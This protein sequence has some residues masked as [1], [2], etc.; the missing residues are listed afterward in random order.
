MERFPVRRSAEQK[1]DF[2]Q[3]VVERMQAQGWEARVET[4][5][6][7]KH[8]NIVIGDP[9]H[10]AAVF[11]AHYDTPADMI[12]PNLMI[13]RNL[14]VYLLYQLLFIGVLLLIGVLAGAALGSLTG[15]PQ[16][17]SVTM[18]VVYFCLLV[19]LNFGRANKNNA[20]DNTSGVAAVLQLAMTI[21]AEQREKVAFILFDNEEKGL[22]GSKMYAK[23]H[24]SLQY[25]RLV[26]NL[27]C[28]GNGD[29]MLVIS[30]DM[31]RRCTGY[32]KLESILS[33]TPGCTALFY[34]S[35][36][37]RCNSDQKNFRC[38]VAVAAFE[39]KAGVGLITGRIHTRRDTVCSQENIDY[40]V[41]AFAQWV[42]EISAK[43]T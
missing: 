30:K 36:A 20:N 29:Q 16:V 37:A 39:R 35:K 10:A 26:I 2:R 34:D 23:D 17:G 6:R 14:P 11:T 18:I 38:G 32:H 41:T 15:N 13:P 1:A 25:M 40:L 22:R 4:T 28:V 12:V 9:E 42:D 24:L 7:G 5:T 21:P 8:Q 31:A 19:F 3:W 43:N 33:Q 27:D